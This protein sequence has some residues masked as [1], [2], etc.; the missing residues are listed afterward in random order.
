M[1]SD[2]Q[3]IWIDH[4]LDTDKIQIVPFNTNVKDI[5]LMIE[6]ELHEVLGKE[7]S[8]TLRGSGSLGI[9]G[10]G[11]LDVYIPVMPKD[12]EM[13]LKMLIQKYG[14][15]R[16]LYGNERARFNRKIDN[17]KIEVFLINRETEG[18]K[19]LNIF[20]EWLKTH[21]KDLK[22]YEKLKAGLHGVSTREY[23]T[24]KTEFFNYILKKYHEFIG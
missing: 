24:K 21:V 17:M 20:E 2:K 11:A 9:S 13:N 4:L 6:K 15:P 18:W 16:S 3:K 1:L 23:Y 14:K 5:Y 12:F 22:A 10:K 8:I 7:I 19:Q